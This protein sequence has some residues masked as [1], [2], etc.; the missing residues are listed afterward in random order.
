MHIGQHATIERDHVAEATLVLLVPTDDRVLTAFENPDDAAFRS[1]VCVAFDAR[2]DAIA[3]HGF[4]EIG[5]GDVDVAPL[6]LDGML[7]HD[8]AEAARIGVHP[9][10]DEIH[11]FRYAEAVAAD[12]KQ[13]TAA[14]ERF[15]LS[16]ETR[17]LLAGHTQDLRE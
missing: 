12:L 8:E 10:D 7:R 16:L 9:A 3:V 2:D 11:L 6:A 5:G 1:L 14:G 17:A 15:E 13:V 4:G